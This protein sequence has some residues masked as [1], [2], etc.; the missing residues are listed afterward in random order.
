ME[1]YPDEYRVMFET[2]DQYWWYH[3]LR[4]LLQSLLARYAP[5]NATI[6]DAGC[7]T[8]ANLQLL[9]SSGRAI[10]VDISAQ[11]ISF[12]RLRGI[13]RDRALLASITDL[14]FPEQF[15]DLIV[16]FDVIC[17]IPDDRQAWRECARVLKPGGRLIAQLPAY[18]SLWSTHDVAVGHQR[19]YDARA[20]RDQVQ[21]VG[22][23][24]ERLTHV[25]TLLLPLM[26]IMRLVNRRALRNGG[27]VQSDLAMRLPQWLN[28]SLAAWSVTEM[29]LASRVNLPA[30]LSILVVA[31]KP[32][33]DDHPPSAVP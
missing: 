8:G 5:A 21:Q 16:S 2:E 1:M 33:P 20:L 14:P 29:R 6:L 7:G 27:A 24:V 25:H 31:R 12:C 22:L 30:G 11:A 13:P 15:F 28:A 19:R 23:R 17:N 32:L 10:G 18:Q 3:G 9:Q 4:T 26:A